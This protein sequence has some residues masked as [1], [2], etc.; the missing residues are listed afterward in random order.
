MKFDISVIIPT[1]NRAHFIQEALQSVL[2]QSHPAHEIIVVDDG[3]KDNTPALAEQF[4]PSVRYIR[5]TNAGPSSARNRGMRAATGNWIAFLDSDDLWVPEKLAS[6]VEFL[7]KFPQVDFLFADM[8]IINDGEDSETP[9]ILAQDVHTYFRDHASNIDDIFACLMKVNAIP[10]SSVLFR[11][12]LLDQVGFFREDLRC[13]EDYE[14]WIRWSF[15]AR[16]GYLQKIVEKRRIH[17]ANIIADRRLMLRT[18]LQVLEET[19]ALFPDAPDEKQKL[20]A[21]AILRQQVNLADECFHHRAYVEAANLLA[22]AKPFSQFGSKERI[23][24]QVKYMVALVASS[25]GKA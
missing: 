5:Q 16:F 19:R 24:Y 18:T 20:W 12:E 14:W 22:K 7:E 21:K 1:Y 23:K 2:Q 25:L 3:S 11:K 13:S 15:Q 17:G 4:P 9:E 6:Q 8:S 10:T